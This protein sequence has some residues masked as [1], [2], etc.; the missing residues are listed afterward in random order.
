MDTFQ[1]SETLKARRSGEPLRSQVNKTRGGRFW[2]STHSKCVSWV[3]TPGLVHVY[4]HHIHEPLFTRLQSWHPVCDGCSDSWQLSWN[5]DPSRRSEGSLSGTPDLIYCEWNHPQFA[6]EFFSFESRSA[7]WVRKYYQPS[8]GTLQAQ[9]SS[10]LRL[11]FLVFRCPL[12]T[13]HEKYCCFSGLK[14]RPW[15]WLLSV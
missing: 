8:S 6:A 7:F 3:P 4:Y 9:G 1:S 11:C 14:N 5:P 10:V 13:S 2:L 15:Q 12:V